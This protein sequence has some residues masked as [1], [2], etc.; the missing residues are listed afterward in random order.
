MAYSSSQT[1]L[2]PPRRDVSRGYAP[3]P[4]LSSPAHH[5]QHHQHQH[6]QHQHH[7]ATTRPYAMQQ[8]QQQQQHPSDQPQQLVRKKSLVKSFRK[9]FKSLK[10]RHAA[11]DDTMNISGPLHLVAAEKDEIADKLW[12]GGRPQ[13]GM[14][15]VPLHSNEFSQKER[16]LVNQWIASNNGSTSNGAAAGLSQ[17]Q[18]GA[19]AYMTVTNGTRTY[20]FKRPPLPPIPVDDPVASRRR[21]ASFDSVYSSVHPQYAID[22]NRAS[23]YSSLQR[24]N[25][26]SSLARRTSRMTLPNRAFDVYAPLYEQDVNEDDEVPQLAADDDDNL[27]DYET[28]EEDDMEAGYESDPSGYSYSSIL[29]SYDVGDGIVVADNGHYDD[30][31]VQPSKEV[32]L[33]QTQTQ[34]PQQPASSGSSRAE[35]TAELRNLMKQLTDLN[36][37]SASATGNNSTNS[38]IS[39]STTSTNSSSNQ[40]PTTPAPKREIR[41]SVINRID[42]LISDIRE[43]DVDFDDDNGSP[44]T[45]RIVNTMDDQ[46]VPEPEPAMRE[47]IVEGM[48]EDA[49]PS[50]MDTIVAPASTTTSAGPKPLTSH[51]TRL[52]SLKRPPAITTAPSNT[53]GPVHISA[54]TISKASPN[55]KTPVSGKV[56]TPF[57]VPPRGISRGAG[58]GTPTQSSS[59]SS[60]PTFTQTQSLPRGPSPTTTQVHPTAMDGRMAQTMHRS[61]S[62]TH[63][64]MTAKGPHMTLPPR[65][66]SRPQTPPP[67][68]RHIVQPTND[69]YG[70]RSLDERQSSDN[71]TRLSV[72]AHQKPVPPLG[73][74]A[75]RLRLE[76]VKVVRVT[77]GEGV[78]G[79]HYTTT[80]ADSYAGRKS[81]SSEKSVKTM[82]SG[83]SSKSM[84]SKMNETYMMSEKRDSGLSLTSS[85]G[86]VVLDGR[87]WSSAPSSVSSKNSQSQGRLSSRSSRS[88]SSRPTTPVT[89]TTPRSGLKPFPSDYQER[90]RTF[91]EDT[92]FNT[93]NVDTTPPP[94]SDYLTPTSS[95]ADSSPSGT[96]IKRSKSFKSLLSRKKSNKSKPASSSNNDHIRKS[97]ISA[98]QPDYY[99]LARAEGM[100]RRE[101][102]NTDSEARDNEYG[103]TFGGE[104]DLLAEIEREMRVRLREEGKARLDPGPRSVWVMK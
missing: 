50:T 88:A 56:L 80:P 66:K 61:P 41:V 48:N 53:P 84:N 94:P 47:T 69:I 39:I 103:K 78:Q 17:Q 26:V 4:S 58:F 51:H 74:D 57:M 30:E 77:R 5:H 46:M 71:H 37:R 33:Q 24:S 104:D 102:S 64:L 98:P 67:P 28:V 86:G 55:N 3:P 25:S 68:H 76:E 72:L 89:A 52:L 11:D 96:P 92:F 2:I 31:D 70:R 91:Y 34:A 65:T 60:T 90:D 83:K 62:P 8:Q 81:T 87:S 6:H 99:T 100:S 21:R 73:P 20:N 63:T 42:Q 9:R 16:D 82:K 49:E 35:E 12:K 15:T 22:I 93:K 40:T 54:R 59:S 7:H 101:W 14:P 85:E 75:I 95:S 13:N 36:N 45:P 19:G 79:Q 32:L 43:V 1:F 38:S 44:T 29:S 10:R 97:S 18:E 23:L 27:L